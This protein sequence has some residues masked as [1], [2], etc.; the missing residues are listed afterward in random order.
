MVVKSTPKLTAII[1]VL[2]PALHY[3][4]LTDILINSKNAV[5]IIF[6]IDNSNEL[7]VKDLETLDSLENSPYGTALIV[8][9]TFGNPGSARNFGLKF[10]KSEWITFWDADDRVSPKIYCDL[11]NKNTCAD[12]IVG[13]F[14]TVRGT[15]RRVSSTSNLIELA[16][17]PG[18]WRIIFRKSFFGDVEFPPLRMGE[19]Q[20]LLMHLNLDNARLVFSKEVLYEYNSMV[21]GQ[22]TRSP[23]ALLEL[24]QSVSLASEC[25]KKLSNHPYRSL[26]LTRLNL[27]VLKQSHIPLSI[28]IRS[29]ISLFGK[30]QVLAIPKIINS[31]RKSRE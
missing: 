19:D 7:S 20:I 13:E 31:R 28:K 8:Q 23:A 27:T 6:V 18:L 16:V 12:V 3:K 9:G 26:I 21:A 4:T 14:E 1:P 24:E 17:N 25:L 10:V 22:L 11:I 30:S 5:D 15:S 29:L 2:N